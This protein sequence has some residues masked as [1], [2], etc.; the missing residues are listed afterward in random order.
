MVIVVLQIFCRG[1]CWEGRLLVD[2]ITFLFSLIL[3][4]QVGVLSDAVRVSSSTS[5]V[6]L[7]STFLARTLGAKTS[8]KTV[9]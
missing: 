9:F 7:K 3:V 4:P 5:L 2:Y 1:I 6:S 8:Y